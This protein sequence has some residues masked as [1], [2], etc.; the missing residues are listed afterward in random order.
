MP[1]LPCWAALQLDI[2]TA[3]LPLPPASLPAQRLQPLTRSELEQKREQLLAE[4]AFVQHEQQ[5][6]RAEQ[7]ALRQE[8][9]DLGAVATL[10][11]EKLMYQVLMEL[12][13]E[14]QH[15]IREVTTTLE[16]VIGRR[17]WRSTERDAYD[18]T[19]V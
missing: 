2:L 17:R 8:N 13:K 9:K 3:S 11:F 6:V 15:A 1:R 12:R 5:V 18:E 4:L 14:R 7:E 16:N 19:F 10:A